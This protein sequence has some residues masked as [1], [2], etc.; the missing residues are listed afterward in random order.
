MLGVTTGK[1]E[2]SMRLLI[3]SLSVLLAACSSVPRLDESE[4]SRIRSSVPASE[5]AVEYA[6]V[7]IWFPGS[8]DFRFKG[9]EPRVQGVAIVTSKAILF[10]QW[11]GEN[12]LTR[13]R[14]IP[15]DSIQAA[16]LN[17]FGRSARIVVRQKN[18]A[19]DSFAASDGNG[20]ISMGAET[21]RMFSSIPE[22]I[23]AKK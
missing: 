4:M 3:L 7:G 11:G 14:S 6:T 2:G 5:G 19:A 20:E 17:T 21:T 22:S 13:A 10:Q 9:I 15:F 23:R 1:S 12:G 18:G 16:S 8:S